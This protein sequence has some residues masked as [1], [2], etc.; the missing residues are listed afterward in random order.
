[1]NGVL[2]WLKKNIIVVVS[3]VLILALL[4]AGW[5]FSSKWNKGIQQTASDEY[6]KQQGA[7]KRAG[8]VSY[9]L[10]SVFQGEGDVS[11]TRPPNRAVTEFYRDQKERRTTQ[12]ANVIE[13][14]TAFN[15]RDHSELVEGLLPKAE[16][17]RMRRQLGLTMAESISGTI[18]P[19][20]TVVTPTVYRALLRRVNAGMPPAADDLAGS[21]QEFNDREEER[22]TAGST[23]GKLSEAQVDQLRRELVNRRLGE[24]AGRAKSLAFYASPE[25]FRGVTADGWQGVPDPRQTNVTDYPAVTE[26]MAFVWQWDYWII[27]D[28]LEAFNRANTDPSTGAATV[29]DGVIKRVERIRLS[30]FEVA[31]AAAVAEE[32]PYGGGGRGGG[33]AGGYSDPGATTEGAGIQ[34]YTGRTGGTADAAYDIRYAEVT[35]VVSTQDLPQLF[36]ALGSVNNMTVIDLDLSPVDVWADLEQGFYYGPDHVMRATF[37]VE[38]VWLRA[39]TGPLMPD[40]VRTKLGMPARAAEN[41]EGESEEP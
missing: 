12:V 22:F 16:S 34:G 32:D 25:A 40:A 28:L 4:P 2:G 30:S 14:G 6:S 27:S 11:E 33:R 31:D 1:M 37:V 8:S 41:P 18:D 24:Y 23:D 26:S 10:P 17:E 29:T 36:E 5:I 20:G 13:R 3:V 15:K 35:A 9:A 39:W 19:D 38:T 21:L 7:L